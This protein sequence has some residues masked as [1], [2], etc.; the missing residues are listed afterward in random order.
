MHGQL[1]VIIFVE[2]NIKRFYIRLALSRLTLIMLK[3]VKKN[4]KYGGDS[5]EL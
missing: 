2:N 1:S 3:I 5:M 4:L